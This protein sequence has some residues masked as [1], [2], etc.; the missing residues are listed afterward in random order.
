MQ[1]NMTHKL[2]WNVLK[3]MSVYA[4]RK[5]FEINGAIAFNSPTKMKLENRKSG[6][7]LS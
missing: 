4:A 3:L 2:A 6:N 5:K 7:C 1:P